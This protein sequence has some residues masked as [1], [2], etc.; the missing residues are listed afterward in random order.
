[1]LVDVVPEVMRALFMQHVDRAGDRYAA[2]GG[3]LGAQVAQL[4]VGFVDLVGSTPLVQELAPDD[5]A[6][7]L[8]DFEQHATEVVAAHHGRVVKTIGDEVM[9]VATTAEAAALI[10][11]DLVE[12]TGAHRALPDVRGGLA[13]GGL[14]RGYADYYGPVVHLAARAVK[15]AR[16]GEVLADP[17]LVEQLGEAESVRVGEPRVYELQGFGE[18]VLLAPLLR[19]PT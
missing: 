7:A 18:P 13:W 10:A 6:A 12:Y 9:Y 16:P 14:V 3:D 11:L 1:M 5:L 8:N 15:V 4:A 17:E 19:A 2:G